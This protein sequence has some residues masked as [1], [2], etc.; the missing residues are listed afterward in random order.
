LGDALGDAAGDALNFAPCI[1]VSLPMVYSLHKCP[2]L[3]FHTV[4]KGQHVFAYDD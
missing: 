1:Y 2:L 3:C 4:Y